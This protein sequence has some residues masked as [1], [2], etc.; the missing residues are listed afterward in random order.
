VI[1][2]SQVTTYA[3][4]ADGNVTTEV[5][6]NC[7]TDS[8]TYDSMN[9]VLS[10]TSTYSGSV[11]Y[12]ESDTYNSQGLV[13]EKIETQAQT[14]GSP[15]TTTDWFSYDAMGRL[16][17]QWSTSATSGPPD[18]WATSF[19]LADWTGTTQT[20]T[21]NNTAGGTFY[22]RQHNHFGPFRRQRRRCQ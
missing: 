9:L 8:Y 19:Q 17:D 1:A 11:L 5:L 22:R 20:L 3:Y 2:P 14:S 16:T 13:V 12:Q 10:E 21:W 4:D 7:V 15:V 6:P 18:G